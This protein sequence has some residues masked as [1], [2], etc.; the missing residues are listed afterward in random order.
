MQHNRRTAISTLALA[1]VVAAITLA[2]KAHARDELDGLAKF[3]ESSAAVVD[4]AA[5]DDFLAKY[6]SRLADGRTAVDYGSVAKA[7]R[8]KLGLYIELLETTDPTTLGRPEAFA[9]WVNL[10]NALTIK[11]VLDR[12][13]VKSIMQI[14]SGI[15]PGPWRNIATTVDGKDLSLDDIEH[16]ILRRGFGDNRVHYACNCASYSCPNLLEKA[17]RGAN[18]EATLDAAAR[19]YVNHPRGVRFDEDRL[20]ASSIY[21]WYAEDF[22]GD[23]AAVI[24]HFREYAEGDLRQRLAS[25]RM[26]SKYAY[27]WGLN[28]R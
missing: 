10:Y 14:R 11:I 16:S 21:K 22:G 2:S 24:A 1:V 4:H 3:D 27:D 6:V 9:Y 8:E 26:I 12:Y 20:V 7:D 13:P 25:V 15:R 18:L 23:E 28:D 19:A 17:F 5:F